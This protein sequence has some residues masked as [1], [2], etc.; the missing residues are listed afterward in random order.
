MAATPTL[1]PDPAVIAVQGLLFLAAVAAVKNLMIEPYE[2]LRLKRDSL[3]TG[4]AD[5]AKGLV[6]RNGKVAAEIQA[7]TSTA[8]DRA[9]EQSAALRLKSAIERDRIIL[10]AETNATAIIDRASKD[11]AESLNAQESKLTDECS[12]LTKEVF[13]QLTRI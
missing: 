8:I 13:Q 6:E 7:A 10:E 4:S 5:A 11:L 12:R 3:T 2:K 1:V 9:K